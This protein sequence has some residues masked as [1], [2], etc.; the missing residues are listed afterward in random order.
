MACLSFCIRIPKFLLA[1]TLL[2]VRRLLY[3]PGAIARESSFCSVDK[4][5]TRTAPVQI[6]P[7]RDGS[8]LT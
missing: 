3:Q 4:L 2:P 5:T 6:A 8:I 1:R 7:V